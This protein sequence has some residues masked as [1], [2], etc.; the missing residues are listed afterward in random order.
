MDETLWGQIT[1]DLLS[2][3]SETLG[4]ESATQ[5]SPKLDKLKA[6]YIK[7]ADASAGG[8]VSNN[9][10]A[11]EEVSNNS[12]ASEEVKLLRR[13][14]EELEMSNRL[15][16]HNSF[17]EKLT[18]DGK[19][20]PAQRDQAIA[21]L[22]LAHKS[23]EASFAESGKV[24]KKSALELVKSFMESIP[25]HELFEE[26]AGKANARATYSSNDD[27]SNYSEESIEMDA[28]ITKYM[29]DQVAKGNKDI[30]YAEARIHIIKEG[31]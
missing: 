3:I 9:S 31:N 22:E 27:T 19:L 8:K 15:A 21:I 4:E 28:R 6:K 29:E 26:K 20:I 18:K 23:G 2:A 30:T 13:R 17:Y 10:E 24:V 14:V 7:A 12:E 16:E 11:S 25:A 5:I 1:S